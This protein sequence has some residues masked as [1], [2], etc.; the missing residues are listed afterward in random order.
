MSLS[1][2]YGLARPFLFGLDAEHAH[3][4]TLGMLA[5]TQ[6]TPLACAYA[7]SRVDDPVTLAGLRF[8]NRV[9]LAAGLD[10]N[11]RCIDAF[12][13]MGFGFVEVGTVTPKPQPGNAKPR[14]FRLP[15]RQAL[16]NRLG[17]NNDGLDAFVANVQRARFRKGRGDRT[18]MLLGLN[19]GKNASTPIERAIDDYLLCLDGVYP[20][21]DYVVVNVSSPNTAN[22]RSLQSDEALDALLATIVERRA[23]LAT[24]HGRRV[25][26]FLKIAP[27]LDEAQVQV[28]AAALQRH[29]MDGVIAS[30]T[31][32]SREAVAGLP[33]AEETGG[34]S[35]V[36]VRE[37][38]NRVIAQFRAALG[39]GFPIIGVGGIMSGED[40]KAKLAAGADVV[41]MYTG[42]I[43]RGPV[44]VREVAEALRT[45]GA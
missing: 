23:A 42:I 30:N 13:A 20:H 7:S 45:R 44:L 28:I 6:N 29:G 14:I 5:R 17:F 31:T 19:I 9:G 25:P 34:L 40:A 26:L 33:H 10:K 21:A 24:Q 1:S 41:Q 3:E 35:G 38:S 4:V 8:P 43:Y 37:A 32:L 12:A 39:A 18:P 36:P 2:L 16:I 15:A 22:L 11:A 27:D